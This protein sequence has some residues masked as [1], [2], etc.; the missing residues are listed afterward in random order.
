MRYPWYLVIPGILAKLVGQA[1]Y[2]SRRGWLWQ[3]P[4]VWGEFLWRLPRAWRQRSAVG[5]RAVKI[6]TGL[7]RRSCGDADEARRLGAQSWRE[8]LFGNAGIENSSRI[9][10]C[11]VDHEA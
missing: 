3:E 4:R 7:N 9:R 8:V 10:A 5:T 6:V 1:R 2:A 11:K